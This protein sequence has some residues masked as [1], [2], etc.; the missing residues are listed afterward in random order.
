M[1][2][3]KLWQRESRTY[4]LALPSIL[5]D[6]SLLSQISAG[7]KHKIFVSNSGAKRRN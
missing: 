1:L 6:I 3:S 5:C 7:T 4:M 2:G